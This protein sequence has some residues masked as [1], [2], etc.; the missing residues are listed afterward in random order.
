[1]HIL[2]FIGFTQLMEIMESTSLHISRLLLLSRVCEA[3]M[4]W[5]AGILTNTV[6]LSQQVA[7]TYCWPI[8]SNK[9]VILIIVKSIHSIFG[10]AT[11]L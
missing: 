7:S 3:W 9:A 2:V 11:A 8:Y 4:P 6:S 1:M 5:G 10:S